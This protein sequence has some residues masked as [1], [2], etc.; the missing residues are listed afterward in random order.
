M[1]FSLN[2]VEVTAKRAA[3]GAGYPWGLA[4]EAG[5]ATRWLCA[6]GQDGIA[7]LMRLLNLGLAASPASHSPKGLTEIWASDAPLCPLATGALLSDC[8]RSLP[9]GRIEMK[10]VANPV[11]LLPFAAGA[12]RVLGSTVTVECDGQIAVVDGKCLSV[13]DRF[14]ATATQITVRVGGDM[15][16]PHPRQTRAAPDPDIWVRLN[17]FAHRTYAPATEE[18]RKLGAGSGLSDND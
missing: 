18:S 10:Q 6:N 3:R 8:A 13:A 5:K 16:I 11:F 2:E 4:E 15:T 14:P 12:S 17:R 9:G 1:S 7:E